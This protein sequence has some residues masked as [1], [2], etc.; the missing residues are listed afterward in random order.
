MKRSYAEQTHTLPTKK[1]VHLIN[2]GE[3]YIGI[4]HRFYKILLQFDAYSEWLNKRVITMQEY[5]F[6]FAI[7]WS[8]HIKIILSCPDY[9]LW[10]QDDD[11]NRLTKIDCPGKKTLEMKTSEEDR[12]YTYTVVA[13]LSPG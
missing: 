11:T 4:S 2:I 5:H 8:D 13:L 10:E 12:Q 9:T 1:T 6:W 3:M 7:A